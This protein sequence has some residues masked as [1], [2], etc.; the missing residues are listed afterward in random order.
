MGT[1][2]GT[3]NELFTMGKREPTEP[4][5][6]TKIKEAIAKGTDRI[7]NDGASLSLKIRGGS[8]LWIYKFRDGVSFRS[9]SLGSYHHGVGLTD[10]RNR[11]N[12]FAGKR[13]EQR[14]PRRGLAVINSAAPPAEPKR[15]EPGMKRMRF[16]DLVESYVVLMDASQKWKVKSREPEFHRSLKSGALGKLW[17]HE[18]N[19]TDVATELQTRWGDAP[20]NADKFRGRIEKVINHAVAKAA[21]EDGP[22][23]ARKEIIGQLIAAAPETVHRPAMK[24]AEVPAFYRELVADG[25]PAARSLAF[26]ILTVARNGEARNADWSEVVD[27]AWI[28]PGGREERSMKE[29]EEHAVPLSPAALALLGQPKKAG[30]IFGQM[31]K[32]ALLDKLHAMRPD[33]DADG[34]FLSTTHGM[35]TSFTSWARKNGFSKQL[36]DIAKAHKIVQAANDAAYE[37]YDERAEQLDTLRPMLQ[38]WADFVTGSAR[39]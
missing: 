27:D 10:A 38:G 34:K 14:I 23:P 2:V 7:L 6:P 39:S 30:L 26:L 35:R 9:T 4:L 5:T 31:G 29:G 37:R 8:A 28:I 21:R 15:A 16:A 20:A 25:S 12:A 13:Y 22:N 18:I 17:A 3:N 33:L 11:R 1:E 36:R 24:Y 32:A 19:H